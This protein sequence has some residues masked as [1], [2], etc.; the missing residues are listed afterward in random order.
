LGL[1]SIAACATA[2]YSGTRELSGSLYVVTTQD[3]RQA[4]A[5][6]LYDALREIRPSLF[7]SN[8]QGEPPI[9]VVDG[10]VSSDPVST[11]RALSATEVHSVTRLSAS[12]ATQRYGLHKSNAVL[13][14]ITL[15]SSNQDS[16]QFAVA[17]MR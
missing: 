6:S 16:E 12:A 17:D 5:S 9:V 13:E 8:I 10:V 3:L 4:T 15:H 7:R 11:L 2:S 1:L 14:V